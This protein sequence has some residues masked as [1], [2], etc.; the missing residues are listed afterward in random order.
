M[1]LFVG[2]ELDDHVRAA[3]AAVSDALRKEIDR[4]GW[5]LRA[6]WVPQDNLH[7]TVWFIGEVADDRAANA[8][9]LIQT[10]FA[11]AA[12]DAGIGGLGAFPPAGLP[13]I[14]WL[15]VRSGAPQMLALY[16]D[17]TERLAPLGFEA[18]SRPYHS[19]VTIARVADAPRGSGTAAIR[20]M[21]QARPGDAGSCRVDHVTV[22]QSR[23]SPK[24]ASYEAVLRVPLS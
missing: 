15:G 16:K 3:A 6:R 4:A 10:P 24:G 8:L 13:R 23:L 20:Q 12:F 22:F 5:R 17:V 14:F 19:H 18:D 2:I 7:I 9:S 21:L 11:V 1:R